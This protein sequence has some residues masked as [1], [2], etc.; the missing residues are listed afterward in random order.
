[1]EGRAAGGKVEKARK[2]DIRHSSGKG[3]IG[4]ENTKTARFKKG[5]E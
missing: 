4:G 2:E 1:M 3:A 5:A